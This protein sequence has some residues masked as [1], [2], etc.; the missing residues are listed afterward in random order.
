MLL[1]SWHVYVNFVSE[2]RLKA[3]RQ[4]RFWE[5]RHQSADG[6]ATLVLD[7]NP[8]LDR[9][10]KAN[11]GGAERPSRPVSVHP[12]GVFV[13]RRWRRPVG[14]GDFPPGV[15]RLCEVNA[16][17]LQTEKQTDQPSTNFKAVPVCLKKRFRPD[18]QDG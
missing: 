16:E 12:A 11:R 15:V 7:T 2:K 9:Q 4:R 3:G 13:S 8:K 18:G 5:I 6:E 17:H 10:L 1:I 14:V